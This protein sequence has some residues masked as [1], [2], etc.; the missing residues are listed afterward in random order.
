MK[1]SVCIS[2]N[3][4]CRCFSGA[5][6][7]VTAFLAGVLLSC[8]AVKAAPW[9]YIW[10]FVMWFLLFAYWA[11]LCRPHGLKVVL[12]SVSS[13]LAA[14]ALCEVVACIFVQ[15]ETEP[16]D[17]R[18]E[19]SYLHGYFEHGH[20]ILGYSARKGVTATA[21][22]Y[23]GTNMVYDVTYTIQEDGLRLSPPSRS[24]ADLAEVWFFGGSF[25]FGEGVNDHEA[26]PYQVGILTGG[27][28][29]VRNFGFHGYG[30]H[31]M[32]A[33]LEHGVAK[34]T[35]SG[36]PAYVI[37]QALWSH[38]WRCGGR[39]S[40]DRTGPRYELTSEGGVRYAGRFSDCPRGRRE[41]TEGW[42]MWHIAKCRAAR[43]VMARLEAPA[44][45]DYDLF[46]AIVAKARDIVEGD[47]KGCQFHAIVWDRDKRLT[48]RLEQGLMAHGIRVHR[49]TEII[50]DI[51]TDPSKYRIAQSE[52]HPNQF[53]YM[54][55]A[56]YVAEKILGPENAAGM[57]EPRVR[58]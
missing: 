54:M 35:A 2:R 52:P 58:Q 51:V 4:G 49:I 53:A 9:P 21:R 10:I 26:M 11:A 32:L 27:A 38:A 13:L 19:G 42:L 30:P 45:S 34:K 41:W 1:L 3:S 39:E 16:P 56:R 48:R 7:C 46:V 57:G 50:S 12:L 29:A 40:W 5:G 33:A 8:V 44:A 37:Y 22:R 23:V 31:Q 47:Y 25:T 24:S 20:P 43:Y 18:C 15:D 17:I 14:C 28:Y 55:I 6:G 36:P